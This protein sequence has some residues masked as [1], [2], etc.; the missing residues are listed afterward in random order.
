MI[1]LEALKETIEKLK[2][3]KDK[4]EIAVQ[5]RAVLEDAVALIYD[6]CDAQMPKNASLLE[7]LDSDVVEMY[8]SD[9]VFVKSLHYVRILGMNAKHG[10]R[11]KKTEAK[12]ALDNVSYLLSYI[13]Q[14]NNTYACVIEKPLYMSE[15][16]TRKLYIDKYIEEAGWEV[17][18]QKGVAVPGKASIEIEVQGMPN[19]QGKGYC[20]YVL[21]D[22]DG[23]PLAIVEAK[24]TS[25]DP[26][27]GRHQLDLYG[28]CMKAVY[29]YKPILYY[30][31]G[32][33]IKVIDGLYPDRVVAGFHSKKELQH[34]LEMR[35]RGDIT[36]MTINDEITNRPYQK[37]AIT[38]MCE[39]LNDNRRRGLLVMA[40]GTGKTRV[41]ISLVDILLRNKWIKNVLFLAD[42]TALVNQAKRAFASLLPNMSICELSGSGDKDL[43]ARL[44]FSTYQTMIRYI[45]AE[46]K[47]FSVGRFDL[48]IIDEAHRSVFNKYGSIFNYFDSFLV[49]LTA[50]PKDEVD[51]N[52][53]K[54][55]GCESGVPNFDYSLKEAVKDEYLVPFKVNNRTT[56]LFDRGTKY[57]DLSVTEKQQLDG[58]LTA[59]KNYDPDIVATRPELFRILYNKDTCRKVL[60][61]VMNYGITV[62]QGEKLG[63][64]IIFAYNHEH[65]KLI[66]EC[67]HEMYPE[68]SGNYCQLVDNYVNYAD[69]LVL[70]FG[71]DDDFRI[72]VSVDM[73]DT[74]IDVPAVT[75]L[76]FFKPIKS[77]IKFAQMIGRGTRLCENLFGKGEHKTHFLIFDYCGNFEYF[78][79]HPDGADP[80]QLYSLT[81]KKFDVGLNLLYE[82]QDYRYQIDNYT[83]KYYDELKGNLFNQVSVIKNHTERLQVREE[84]EYVDKYTQKSAWDALSAVDVRIIQSHITRLIDSGTNDKYKVIAFDVRMM[85]IQDALLTSGDITKAA[86]SVRR[87]KKIAKYLIEEK[88][89]LDQV[90]E[91]LEELLELQQDVFWG[92]AT[93]EAIEEKRKSL[94]DL[95][96][97]VD[98]SLQSWTIDIED[99]TED[100]LI[101]GD[102]FGWVDIRTYREKVIDYLLEHSD[103]PVFQKIRQLEPINNEDLD[104]LERILWSEL[105]S[106]EDFERVSPSENVAVFIRSLV[107]LDQIVINKKFGEYLSSNFLNSNQQEFIKIIISYVRENGDI[108]KED[109]MDKT[110]FDNYNLIELFGDKVTAVISVV[111]AFHNSINVA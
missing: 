47:E 103:S 86:P 92:T 53:Y 99:K 55:F 81:Q 35:N 96:Q 42:R 75:N 6:S 33:T 18:E 109:L 87:V 20:D 8:L 77:K 65:A 7:L 111:D 67:F 3:S 2:E 98:N 107:G 72:A 83:K 21:Y 91:K 24:K 100:A 50:T 76:V 36:D 64:T 110:P 9:D 11:I 14:K 82:L 43:N 62:E 101:S 68:H 39:R 22:D 105:G 60:E 71:D 49:G 26:V 66:V 25:V 28:E 78:D 89:S 70:K 106:K 74:G 52:T 79:L 90:I 34:I 31:N 97:F 58:Y 23:K 19:G 4:V 17:L 27:K 37:I 93:F 46:E 51:S 45:D 13:D 102:E 108:S 85:Q 44:M 15:Y 69:D 16:M 32:Y 5:C 63:K 84:M 59:T 38:K 61:D 30:T 54:L 80:K 12:L 94:R 48:V 104:E 88:A 95:A 41:A 57:A 29:G 10:R 56:K 73:L 1:K 40:T